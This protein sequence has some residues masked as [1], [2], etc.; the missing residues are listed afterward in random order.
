MILFTVSV[1]AIKSIEWCSAINAPHEVKYHLITGAFIE[2]SP[3]DVNNIVVQVLQSSN[4]NL[5]CHF[6]GQGHST[7]VQIGKI[8]FI[9]SKQT[10][11]KKHHVMLL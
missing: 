4:S 9:L 6:W 5:S 7:A 2:I 10:F 8:A 3:D 11:V 1:F